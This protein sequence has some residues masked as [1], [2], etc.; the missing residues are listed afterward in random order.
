MGP[1]AR[2]GAALLIANLGAAGG[3][4]PW[5]PGL[6]QDFRSPDPQDPLGAVPFTLARDLARSSQHWT[7][8]YPYS[9]PGGL[10]SLPGTAGPHAARRLSVIV[11]V[12]A[13]RRSR[14]ELG[15]AARTRG[16]GSTA[17]SCSSS[18]LALAAPVG[19][20]LVS[21]TG[22]HI[23]GV[24][25]LAASWPF[26]ALVAGAALTAAP[27]PRRPVA[28][29]LAVLAFAIG[30]VRRCSTARFDRPD[31]QAAAD[32]I[33]AHARPGDV[34][35]DETG[36]LSPGPLT[37]LDVALHPP[38]PGRSAPRRPPSATTRTASST[39]SSRSRRRSQRGGAPH[40]V[41]ACS[42]SRMLFATDINAAGPARRPGPEPVP[43]PYRLAG[44]QTYTGIGQT[45]VAVYAMP[46]PRRLSATRAAPR[47]SSRRPRPARRLRPDARPDRHDRH[48]GVLAL[49]AVVLLAEPCTLA[50]LGRVRARVNQQNQSA[51]TPALRRDVPGDPAAG[52][53]VAATRG[54]CDR[55]AAQCRRTL[56]P[57]SA[58]PRG[59][60]GRVLIVIRVS[61]DLP[62]GDGLGALLAG[63]GPVGG[64]GAVSLAHGGAAGHGRCCCGCASGHT[65]RGGRRGVLAVGVLLC[66]TSRRRFTS[67][68]ALGARCG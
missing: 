57:S 33:A 1:P 53:V 39:R 8:G 40:A 34:V 43:A 42:W 55:R 14:A 36:A 16:R 13:C 41:I 29:G 31:Y 38:A 2:L 30:G 19:E 56:P 49:M 22:D 59:R 68:L 20:A 46:V 3:L 67:L 5:L 65:G 63:I 7:I 4:L 37:G 52:A 45:F 12:A 32:Y 24:R 35:V 25:N 6:I 51:K 18:L 28:V 11:A 62:W 44:E 48:R 61:V 60:A 50:G 66:V 9:R 15:C 26:L 47:Q 27:A 23:F 58:R 21:A 10:R 54:R 64:G 17:G